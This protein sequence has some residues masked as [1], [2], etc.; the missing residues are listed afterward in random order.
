MF[1]VWNPV[2]SPT[3]LFP[4]LASILTN[5]QVTP[6]EFKPNYART[7]KFKLTCRDNR[8]AGGG[9]TNNDTPVQIN[10]INTGTPFAITQPNVTGITYFSNTLQTITW[11]VGSTDVAPISTPNVNIYF[12]TDGGQTFPTVIAFNAPNTGSYQWLTPIITTTTARVWVE[13][14]G[15]AFFDINDKNFAINGI[16]NVKENDLNNTISIYPN[17]GNDMF[18]FAMDNTYFGS[19]M[20]H[21][22]DKLGRLVSN[23]VIN[24]TSKQLNTRLDLLNIESGI[25]TVDFIFSEQ[26][27]PKNL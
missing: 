16:L 11:N 19:V 12:S 23:Q 26:K 10:V 18:N 13:G 8:F 20:V 27:Q 7:M 22:Y 2:I 15:N 4:R 5:T 17:P 21:V 9:V 25:Y 6:G 24:K 14:A 3:R 1:R